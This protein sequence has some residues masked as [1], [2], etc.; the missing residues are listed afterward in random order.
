MRRA[1]LTPGCP[2]GATSARRSLF[3]HDH[4]LTIQVDEAYMLLSAEVLGSLRSNPAYVAL[5]RE[6]MGRAESNKAA[7]RALRLAR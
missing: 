6:L 5:K 3:P 4:P 2:P 7:A 1:L